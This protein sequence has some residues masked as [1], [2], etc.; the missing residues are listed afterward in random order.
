ME[1][2]LYCITDAQKTIW[3]TEKFYKDNPIVNI[4]GTCT[5]NCKVNF[6]L[7]EKA[8]NQVVMNNDALRTKITIKNGEPVQY[9]E[10]YNKF[11]V[12][13]YNVLNEKDLE[14][15]IKKNLN[16]PLSYKEDSMV[17]FI[18][19]KFPDGTGGVNIVINHMISD[20]WS[21]I[22]ISSEVAGTYDKLLN[23]EKDTDN[24]ES[25]YINYIESEK[26]YKNSEK[27][28]KDKLF[29]ER[30]LSDLPEEVASLKQ[31]EEINTLD[32]KAERKE[33]LINK[34]NAEKINKYCKDNKISQYVFFLGIYAIYLSKFTSNKNIIINTPILNRKNIKEKNTIGMFVNSLPLKINIDSKKTIQ[35]FFNKIAQDSLSIFRHQRYSIFEILNY[36]REKNKNN[37][38]IYD[39]VFSYQNAVSKPTTNNLSYTSKWYF[40]GNITETMNIHVSDLNLSG[41]FYIYY[42]Y[43]ISQLSDKDIIRM[44]E[45]IL[46]IIDQILENNDNKLEEISILSNN[47]IKELKELNNTGNIEKNDKTVNT[48]ID[49]ICKEYSN[50]IAM[51]CKNVEI[52]YKVF[53]DKVNSLAAF[54]RKKGVKQNVPVAIML[55]KS[56]EMIVAMF[57][58]IRAG[59]YYIPILPDEEQKRIDYIISDSKPVCIITQNNYKYKIKDVE[60]IDI[61]NEQFAQ[62]NVKS[63]NRPNDALYMIYTSGST[64]NPKGTQVMHK[65]VCGL[66]ESMKSDKTLI[67]TSND[68]SMSLLKYSFDAS[69][70][71]IYS[72]ILS[73]GKLLLIDKENELNPQIIVKI[74]EKEKVTRSFLI[75]KWVEQIAIEDQRQETDLSMLKILGT[76]GETLK[77]NTVEHLFTKYPKLKILNLYGPTETTMFTTYKVQSENEFK[78]NNTSIG[79][80]IK[81]SRCLILNEENNILPPK[82][83]G[84]LVIYEDDSSIKNISKG[85]WNLEEET[86]KRFI[87][88]YNPI[89]EKNVR[90]YKTGDIVK[91]NEKL[92]I[93]YIGRTDDMVKVNG[94][95]LVALNEIENII[96][97]IINKQNRVSVV[98]VPQ[99]NTKIIVAFIEGIKK[100]EVKGIEKYINKNITFYMRPKKVF[101]KD[102][103]PINN[104]G[105]IDKKLLKGIA[106]EE[107]K[108]INKKIV[109]PKKQTEQ[110]IYNIIKSNTNIEDFSIKDDFINDLGIDSLTIS[111]IF[112]EL[113]FYKLKLQ[114]LYTYSTVEDLAKFIDT[115]SNE[116]K[117]ITFRDVEVKNDSK[118]FNIS[119]V[120]LTGATGFLGIH[121]LKELLLEKKVKNI[122]CI[123]RDKEFKTG[124]ERL[125]ERIDFYF[126]KRNKEINSLLNKKVIVLNGNITKNNLG[127]DNNEY[128]E[129]R[130]K[131]TTVIN[132]GAN[133]RHYC[134]LEELIKDNVDSVKNIMEFCKNNI[135]LAHISTLSIAGFKNEKTLSKVFDENTFYIKQDF[136]NNPYLIS[137]CMAEQLLLESNMSNIKIFR[138][139]NIMPR[140][141]DGKFQ[142]NYNKNAFINAFRNI[143]I[144]KKIPE[145]IMDTMIEFSPVDECANS[146]IKIIKSD[147]NSKV[148]HIVSD[149]F[150]TIKELFYILNKLCYNIDIVPINDFINELD[151]YDEIGKQYIKE[152]IIQNNINEYSTQSTIKLLKKKHFRWSNIDKKYIKKLTNLIDQNRW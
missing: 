39:M 46:N 119:N 28:K 111:T 75:P 152:Y 53:Y 65:N 45:R 4:S 41:E 67:P 96:Y 109:E 14:Q 88:I 142:I 136:N 8:I 149:K 105:K 97:R 144:S 3:N 117:I 73:G 76:G 33:I 10:D 19:F 138:L 94:S 49:E 44:H 145:E 118:E 151:K 148:F 79:K 17:K 99:N 81:L 36:V 23:N 150:I 57:G 69:G 27:Y 5:I 125:K 16:K 128:I 74:M 24:I 127:L 12:K 100:E 83:K 95:Y 80:P 20:A 13:T 102:A 113:G 62:E 101:A 68:I 114:D 143:I 89:V 18:M 130:K 103:F 26:E 121:L 50:N 139:G 104:S 30:Y 61:F 106:I 122:Y 134:K 71:D 129:L 55:D 126:G 47:D 22:L 72:S 31:K 34:S 63:I 107:L 35:E 2:E 116:K 54:L 110:I 133:V 25:S 9:F 78:E 86:K 123:I 124:N 132:C 84:E 135:Y 137:K 6:E 131:I 92:D 48:I 70:I 7:L 87:N 82:A 91:L 141:S 147:S 21:A 112:S 56:I 38:S 108:A 59:G 115:G 42:D 52:T 85:Y 146:I 1:K 37:S 64:G 58:I 90:I 15:L 11:K 40:N 51:K 29:W 77:P 43:K 98:A 66:I 93:E 120:L 140:T 32:T 60:I